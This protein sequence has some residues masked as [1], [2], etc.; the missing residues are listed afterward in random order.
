MKIIPFRRPVRDDFYKLN[1]APVA[2]GLVI[3]VQVLVLVLAV[4][5]LCLRALEALRDLA[6]KE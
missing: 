2:L 6:A 4:P 3:G 5:L 1:A